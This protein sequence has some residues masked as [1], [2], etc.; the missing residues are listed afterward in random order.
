FLGHVLPQVTGKTL[1]WLDAHMMPG[2]VTAGLDH[3]CPVLDEI[4]AIIRWSKQDGYIFVDDARLFLAPAA[5]PHKAD[6]WPS[7][8]DVLDAFAPLRGSHHIIVSEDVLMA[9]PLEARAF[10][11]DY[12]QR[13]AQR[14][15]EAERRGTRMMMVGARQTARGAVRTAR[16]VLRWISARS[17][18]RS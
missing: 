1:F 12:C 10:L 13:R 4:G 18:E 2:A 6:Q 8:R 15:K 3:E 11:V 14:V 9:V 16:D 5:L 7:I 17:P